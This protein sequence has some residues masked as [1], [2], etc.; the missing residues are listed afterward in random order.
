[1]WGTSDA[2]ALDTQPGGQAGIHDVETCAHKITRW[3]VSISSMH[4]NRLPRECSPDLEELDAQLGGEEGD[5][6]DDGQAHAPVLVGRQLRYG[7]QQALRQEVD[8]DDRVHL[9]VQGS[10]SRVYAAGEYAETIQGPRAAVRCRE[11]RE[12]NPQ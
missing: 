6:V 11:C 9:R 1:M 7:W 10:G 12:K 5:V 2:E 3:Y 8:A 4:R